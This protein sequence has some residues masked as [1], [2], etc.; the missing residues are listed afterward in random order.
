MHRHGYDWWAGCRFDV[1]SVTGDEVR[2][3][4]DAFWA[5]A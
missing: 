4:E 3:I 2:I 5:D 1:V